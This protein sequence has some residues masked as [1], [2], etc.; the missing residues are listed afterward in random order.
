MLIAIFFLSLAIRLIYLYQLQATPLF[1]FFAADSYHYHKF[2]LRMAAGDFAFKQ[3]LYISPLYPV[4]LLLTYVFFGRSF[5]A[6]A[7]LQII[8]DSLTAVFIYLICL[9]VFR[10]K[11]IAVLASLIYA[12]YALA[13]LYTGLLL[14]TTLF[15]FLCVSL[16]LVL[17]RAKED[18]AGSWFFPGFIFGLAALLKANII[19]FLPFLIFW[20]ILYRAKACAVKGKIKIITVLFSGILLVSF[21]FSLR[22]YMLEK[23]VLPLSVHGGINF[24]IGNNPEARGTYMSFEGISNAPI[25]QVETAILKAQRSSGKILTPRESSRYWFLKGL[26]FI[27]EN[28]F[29]YL[30]LLARKSGL[31]LS[32]DEISLNVDYH[33]CKRFIPLF[34]LP[35]FAFGFI[36]PLAVLGLVLTFRLKNTGI[37]LVNLFVIAYMLSLMAFFVVSRYRFPCVPFLIILAAFFL[38]QFALLIK[39]GQIKKVVLFSLCLGALFILINKDTVNIDRGLSFAVAHTNLA[40]AYRRQGRFKTAIAENQKALQLNPGLPHAYYNIG[41][42]YTQLGQS[43]EAM[44]MF[45]KAIEFNPAGDGAYYNMGVIRKQAGELKEAEKLFQKAI[46]IKPDPDAY[47][48]LALIYISLNRR[49]RAAENLKKAAELF[50]IQGNRGGLEAVRKGYEKIKE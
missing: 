5:L 13:F 27:R 47:Y 14:D 21:P 48:N 32:S 25:E 39:S 16:I 29:R 30:R 1:G 38:H 11:I 8:L 26:Q 44:A 41:V 7:F 49:Q 31:F 45:K 34:K 40:E 24:Y 43:Q 28:P 22:N 6:V 4:F 46:A 50:T 2:A 12:L 17:L 19:F 33:F 37:S 9:K 18:K 23:R 42:I 10:K 35:F 15:T 36:A 20:I 3:V